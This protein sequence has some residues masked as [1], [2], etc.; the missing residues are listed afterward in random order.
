MTKQ[1]KEQIYQFYYNEYAKALENNSSLENS[2]K[3]TSSRHSL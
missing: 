1:E 2:E 3:E